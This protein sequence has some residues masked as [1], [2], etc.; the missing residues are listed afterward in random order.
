MDTNLDMQNYM[1]PDQSLRVSPTLIM[2]NSLLAASSLE[3]QQMVQA[4]LEQN[5]ALESVE[6]VLCMRCGAGVTGR[7]CPVCAQPVGEADDVRR[8]TPEDRAPVAG[9]R[10]RF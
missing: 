9:R 3:L 4:E 2:V 5:P 1:S 6:S 10:F 8:T 7:Y